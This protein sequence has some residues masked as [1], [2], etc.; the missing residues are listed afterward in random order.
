[1]HGAKTKRCNTEGCTSEAK[2]GG[3]C[4]AHGAKVKLCNIKAC[5][6]R[7]VKGGVCIAQGTK[8][9]QCNHEGCTNRALRRGFCC[10]HGAFSPVTTQDKVEWPPQPAEGYEATVTSAIARRGVEINTRNVHA[11][12]SCATARQS[13]S[14]VTST[15]A[16][17]FPDDDEVCAWI[18]RSSRM[19]RLGGEVS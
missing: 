1:M 7:A 14:L 9:K 6:N 3:D 17:N 8:T 18:W 4:I 11:N 19:A 2:K 5:A 12:I 13:P 16:M 10:R 15:M